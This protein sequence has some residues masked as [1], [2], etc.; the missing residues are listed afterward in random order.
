MRKRADRASSHVVPA[1]L[2]ACQTLPCITLNALSGRLPLQDHVICQMEAANQLSAVQGKSRRA[3]PGMR[4]LGFDAQAASLLLGMLHADPAQR[5]PAANV[6]A[7]S[8]LAEVLPLLPPTPDE[9]AERLAGAQAGATAKAPPPA[10]PVPAASDGS[11]GD[12]QRRTA[13]LAVDTQCISPLGGCSPPDQASLPVGESLGGAGCQGS[14]SASALSFSALSSDPPAARCS[15]GAAPPAAAVAA[16]A[17]GAFPVIGHVAKP[18]EVSV[19]GQ[20][21]VVPCFFAVYEVP[22]RGA[23]MSAQPVAIGQPEQQPAGVGQGAQGELLQGQAQN[24]PAGS[25]Q[26]MPL[27]ARLMQKRGSC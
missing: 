2:T 16:P 21:M 23:M 22:G 15:P 12:I 8:W 25:G 27:L 14:A 5:L 7:H 18:M 11:L 10:P 20:R 4:V 19:G 26:F 9:L 6:A 13:R 3:Q 1:C 17:A 24:Q